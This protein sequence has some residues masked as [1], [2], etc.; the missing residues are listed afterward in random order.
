MNILSFNIGSTSTKIAFSSGGEEVL[1]ETIEYK[2][3]TLTRFADFGE[4]LPIRQKDIE[5]FVKRQG[6]EKKNLD[7]I[8]SRGGIGKPAPAGAYEINEVMCEDVLSGRYGKHP[9]NLGPPI[10]YNMARK[11]GAKSIVVDP[12]T[13]DEFHPLARVTGIPELE[14][15]SGF[16]ALNQKA[17][18]R[19]AARDMGKRYADINLVVAHLGGGITIGTHRKGS[20]IDVTHG[21]SEGPLTP[22]RAGAL[23]T[24][25]L[26]ELAFSGQFDM[27]KLQKKLLGQGG[28]FA[29]FGTSDAMKVEK[30]IR[31]GD[32]K[33]KFIYEVMIYQIAKDIGAMAAVLKGKID[34]IVLTGGLAQ[35]E[36]VTSGI[37]EYVE[38]LAPVFIY[39]GE[40]EMRALE[41]GALRVLRGEEEIKEYI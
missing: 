2:S 28:L 30:M 26:L 8:V 41:E 14:R 23:P 20:A 19:R 33:A 24:I 11:F 17:A 7:M 35:S 15:Q 4:Q 21:L 25:P 18:A 31:E 13:T 37:K 27:K 12:P 16:H 38:F 9:A 34:G 36:M 10:A 22:E 39:P 3:E 1:R 40:D 6:L 32:E 29:Y 5:A